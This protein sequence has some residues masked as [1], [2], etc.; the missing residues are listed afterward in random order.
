MNGPY[1]AGTCKNPIPPSQWDWEK[2][3]LSRGQRYRVTKTFLDA[4]GDLH[5]VGEEWLFIACMFSRFDDEL[6]VCVQLQ[7]NDEW[8]VPLIWRPEAQQEIIENFLDYVA[9]C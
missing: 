8:K 3:R 5:E 1:T 7:S 9:L 4:D 6:I 2:K